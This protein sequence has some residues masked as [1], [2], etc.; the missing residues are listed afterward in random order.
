MA[1]DEVLVVRLYAW[2]DHAFNWLTS[3]RRYN[4]PSQQTIG[5]IQKTDA[6][7]VPMGHKL[8]QEKHIEWRVFISYGDKLLL[9]VW[10]LNSNQVLYSVENDKRFIMP[11]VGSDAL[12]SYHLKTCLFYLIENTPAAIWQP[13]NILLCVDICLRQ[14]C[15]WIKGKYC[16][17]YFILEEN[18][19]QCQIYGLIPGELY[20]ILI[21]LLLQ[22][23]IYLV[24]ISCD[25]V[26]EM[27]T[28]AC[29]NH[30]LE[31]EIPGTNV[32]QGFLS[33]VLVI[34]VNFNVIAEKFVHNYI[35]VLSHIINKMFV[36]C[37]TPRREIR[38]ILWKMLCSFNSSKL[39]SEIISEEI[40]DEHALDM[41]QELLLWGSS[42]DVTSGKLKLAAFYFI[43]SNIEITEDVL[44]EIHENYSYTILDQTGTFEYI[45]Q[46]QL[47]EDLSTT[48]LTSR[49][50]AFPVQ[51]HYLEIN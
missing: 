19:F 44:N 26:G 21:N 39:A 37:Q 3:K 16:P 33:S 10:K 36:C 30:L 9:L 23:G 6:L 45:L 25:N 14:L 18:M 11:V 13:D 8:S 28:R 51:Y 24:W 46:S 20:N 22:E 32:A 27:L 12:I 7:L 5:L 29:Q 47:S 1:Q 48:Q 38:S 17:N 41:S 15:I 31:L 50:V 40:E 4:W 2:P 34:F 42:S 43:Q 35:Y 49:Y